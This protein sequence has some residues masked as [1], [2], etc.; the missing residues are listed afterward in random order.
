M[1][2]IGLGVLAYVFFSAHDATIKFLV[3]SLPVWQIL[4]VRSL[5]H[6]DRLPSLSGARG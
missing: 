3:A 5:D 6:H 1:A 2:G 4:F